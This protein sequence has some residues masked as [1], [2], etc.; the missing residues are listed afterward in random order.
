[1]KKKIN[2]IYPRRSIEDELFL[3]DWSI[4]GGYVRDYGADD[5]F[6]SSTKLSEYSATNDCWMRDDTLAAPK[7]LATYAS[8]II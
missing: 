5:S 4:K 2:Q 3:N 1:M 6:S 7:D 8:N